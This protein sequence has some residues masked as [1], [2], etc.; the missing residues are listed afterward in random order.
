[1]FVFV[2]R[3]KSSVHFAVL[4]IQQVFFFVFADVF[5]KYSKFF[6]GFLEQS[7]LDQ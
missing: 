5:S 3:I 6:C 4:T 1:M 7:Q 2:L